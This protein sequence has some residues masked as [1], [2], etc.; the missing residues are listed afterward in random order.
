MIASRN[1]ISG[2]EPCHIVLSIISGNPLIWLHFE[3]GVFFSPPGQ[4]CNSSCTQ[5]LIISPPSFL[6]TS[7][8]RC[9]ALSR[10]RVALRTF[11][12]WL[13]S[14]LFGRLLFFTG[15]E[16]LLILGTIHLP[17]AS[18]IRHPSPSNASPTLCQGSLGN[19]TSRVTRKGCPTKSC[20]SG[21]APTTAALNDGRS[22]RLNCKTWHI[23]CVLCVPRIYTAASAHST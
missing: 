9:N 19:K 1:F 8:L 7:C 12:A 11:P 21:A 4:Q 5:Y 17:V 18:M 2:Q 14:W 16:C 3:N 22:P 15:I 6:T 10:P 13:A 20:T 23:R